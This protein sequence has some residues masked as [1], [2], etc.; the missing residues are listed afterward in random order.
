MDSGDNS[1]SL[2]RIWMRADVMAASLAINVLG[3][4]LPIAI[5]QMYD[6][7]IRH[8]S[9]STLAVLTLA[10]FIAFSLEFLLRTLRARIMSVEG[11]RYDHRENYRTLERLLAVDIDAF[12]KDTPGTHADRFHAIQSVR[13][14]YCQA[15]SLLADAPFMLVFVGLIAIIAGWMAVVP[16]IL[17]AGFAA[18]G[19]M[20]ARHLMRE[21]GRRER[22]DTKR[23][24]FLVECIGGI[25][26]V[27]SLGL[28]PLM[29]RRYERL[30]E[31][32]A[33]AFGSIVR[34]TT[35]TQSIA[36]ELAQAASILTVAIGAIA[37]VNGALTI[38]GLAATTILTGRLLQPVLKGLGLWS[39]YPFIRLAEEKIRR[40][41]DLNPRLVGR[42]PFP[43]L[44]DGILKLEN[45]SFSYAG[46][47]RNVVDNLTL[48][49]PPR[50]FVGLTGSTSS[51]RTTLLK[52]MNGLL[53]ATEGSIR[54]DDV[55]V[56]LYAPQDLRR[57]IAMMPTS[58]TIYSGTLLENLTLFEDGPVKR[59][60]LALCRVLGLEDYVAGLSR[61]LETQLSG[62]GDTPLGIAQRI[63]IIRSLAQDPRIILFDTA[64]A[65]LDH[66]ADRM[67]LQY[68][69]RQKGKR[70]AVFVTDRPSYLRMCDVVY[71]MADGRL[72]QRTDNG[73]PTR[74]T[75]GAAS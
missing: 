54:Y 2:R 71:E 49:I 28:E 34:V 61:G 32:A 35:Q 8:H 74:A 1:K 44:T 13:T 6:R 33:D 50:T 5:L 14:F 62:A 19:Y 18:L 3:L 26:T 67:L 20:I 63:S 21:T 29:Q 51:G 23:H 24:N 57:Q 38:G 69:Q 53:T 37:V 68:F 48:E 4:A 55:P 73:I 56:S 41:E 7:V 11:A 59:R 60:A 16:L 25:T 70:S 27:K 52:L 9:F 47:K 43:R 22:C 12:K 17:F 39:R 46:A 36:G 15:S 31:E 75:V 45:V 40:M 42:H 65:A 58:P 64:N 66:D 10:V 72:R 30:Q